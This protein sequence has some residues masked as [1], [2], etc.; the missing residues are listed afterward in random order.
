MLPLSETQNTKIGEYINSNNQGDSGKPYWIGMRQYCY[1]CPF[2]NNDH[3]PVDFTSWADGEPNNEDG[4]EDC[5]EFQQ[6]G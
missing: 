3:S 5:V 2:E 4:D 1:N 6:T